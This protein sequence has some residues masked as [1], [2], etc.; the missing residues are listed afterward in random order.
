[1]IEKPFL[2]NVHRTLKTAKEEKGFEETRKKIA[3][4]QNAAW[5]QHT[6][7]CSKHSEGAAETLF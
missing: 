2:M 6:P 4:R 1:M 5:T 3:A 7:S